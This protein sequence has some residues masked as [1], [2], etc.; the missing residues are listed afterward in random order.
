MQRVVQ[1]LCV[2]IFLAGFGTHPA[3]ADSI[4]TLNFDPL[5]YT[6]GPNGTVHLT[7]TVKNTGTTTF[8]EWDGASYSNPTLPFLAV[9]ANVPNLILVF[10]TPLLP[11]QSVN[12]DFIDAAFTDAPAGFY[13]PVSDVTLALLDDAGNAPTV[14]APFD[15]TVEVTS[16]VPEPGTLVLLLT[17]MVSATGLVRRRF[18][19]QA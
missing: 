1:C 18:G 15:P 5:G 4:F 12:F 2:L 8:V 6:T 3:H 11:G 19:L 13:L 10:S 7:A 9:N 17:G 14:A 16:P